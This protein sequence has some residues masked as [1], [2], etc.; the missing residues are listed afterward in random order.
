[1]WLIIY[2]NILPKINAI[3]HA[4][5]PVCKFL[6]GFSYIWSSWSLK[7]HHHVFATIMLC[8]FWIYQ[9]F[10]WKASKLNA[11]LL[12]GIKLVYRVIESSVVPTFVS[13]YISGTLLQ[14]ILIVFLGEPFNISDGLKKTIFRNG[15]RFGHLA[16]QHRDSEYF[17]LHLCLRPWFKC[18]TFSFLLPSLLHNSILEMQ[19]VHCVFV[20]IALVLWAISAYACWTEVNNLQHLKLTSKIAIVFCAVLQSSSGLRVYGLSPWLS[21]F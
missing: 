6:M 19:I 8:L 7:Y 1:M 18:L 13:N 17:P 14:S 11:L 3:N 2:K 10:L 15:I 9:Y 4:P 12:N 5:W 20:C 21:F 16:H